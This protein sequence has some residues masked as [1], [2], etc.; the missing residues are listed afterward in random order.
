V[1]DWL[2]IALDYRCNLRCIGC[3]ACLDTGET[4]TSRDVR[5]VLEEHRNIK[6]LWIGGGEPTLREDLP[7]IIATARR[8]GFE[9]VLLQT[10]ALRLAYPAYA[11]ALIAAGLTD[12][13]VN[14]KSH[15]ADVH[16]RL[17]GREGAH[18]LMLTALDHLADVRRAADVLVTRSTAPELPDTVRMLRDRGVTRI[19]L[20]L[21]SA[22]D[23]DDP[24]VH[25]EVPR[26]SEVP[27]EATF[28]IEGVEL[29]SLHTPPCTLPAKHAARYL[30]ARE[31]RL[32]VVDPSKRAFALETSPFEGGA[33][34][35]TCGRCSS[36]GLCHGPRADYVRLHGASEFVPV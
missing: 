21:L 22:A 7:N 9:R 16:D 15:R 27:W 33:Y 14:V 6:N 10:N 12:V 29:R 31:L 20:W 30:P 26:I 17:S 36:R 28:A 11:R 19:T 4:L 13:S 1:H 24:D 35:P 5:A 34:E 3:R 23:I 25:A 32:L 8:M 18:A 2:E